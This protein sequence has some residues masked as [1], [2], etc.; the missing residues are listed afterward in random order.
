MKDVKLGELKRERKENDWQYNGV[1]KVLEEMIGATI[2]DN[3]FVEEYRE[4]GMGFEYEK[5]GVKKRV[6]FG[7]NELG[8]WVVEHKVI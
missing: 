4:G 6:I 8:E 1:V 3:G 2:L 5:D 7:Y